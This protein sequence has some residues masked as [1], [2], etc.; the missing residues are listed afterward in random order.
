MLSTTDGKVVRVTESL[1]NVV[2]TQP[3][4]LK[5]S[6][7]CQQVVYIS[8]T[9]GGNEGG[10][11]TLRKR[12]ERS[13]KEKPR[14]ETEAGPEPRKGCLVSRVEQTLVPRARETKRETAQ[15]D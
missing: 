5:L 14:P 11:P 12:G 15:S 3:L 1:K 10:Y 13:I 2:T 6:L 4:V 7:E 9:P 8:C